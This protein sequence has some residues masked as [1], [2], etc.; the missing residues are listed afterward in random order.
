MDITEHLS[1]EH[2]EAGRIESREFAPEPSAIRLARSFVTES[3]AAADVDEEVL[4]LATSE[5]ASNAVLHAGTTF[6]VSVEHLDDGI[7]VGVT[8]GAPLP[9]PAVASDPMALSGRGLAIVRSL[10]RRVEVVASDGG[11]TVWFEIGGSAR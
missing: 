2:R 11:K 4:A 10:C 8:D 9:P 5:L 7:R 3:A 1:E 6:V